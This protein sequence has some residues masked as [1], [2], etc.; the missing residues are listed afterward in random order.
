MS[1]RYA[2]R[3]DENQAAIVQ[4][5]RDVPGLYVQVVSDL[6]GLGFDLLCN[7]RGGRPVFIEIKNPEARP[8][9][10]ES[11]RR[12]RDHWGSYWHMVTTLDEALAALGVVDRQEMVS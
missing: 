4:A 3:T 12:A 6:P 2:R 10:T 1:G 7:Y 9:L 8:S 11:E 5:L